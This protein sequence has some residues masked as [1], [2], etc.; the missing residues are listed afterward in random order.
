MSVRF[1]LRL[2]CIYG[3]YNKTNHDITVRFIF[4]KTKYAIVC[5]IRQTNVEFQMSLYTM[6]V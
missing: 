6:Y 1:L 3:T 4:N 5:T 2:Y